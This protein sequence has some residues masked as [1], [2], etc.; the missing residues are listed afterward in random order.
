MGEEP[1]AGA[2]AVPAHRPRQSGRFGEFSPNDAVVV[3]QPV[4]GFVC[5]ILMAEP[6]FLSFS[7][8]LK[9]VRWNCFERR[10]TLNKRGSKFC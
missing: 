3:L 8:Y 7:P 5:V 4:V 6:L 10:E 2:A 9:K 1:G